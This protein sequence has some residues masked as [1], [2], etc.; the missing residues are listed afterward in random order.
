MNY[1]SILLHR[2]LLAVLL[3]FLFLPFSVAAYEPLLYL[4]SRPSLVNSGEQFGQ[5]AVIALSASSYYVVQVH[6]GLTL[7]GLIALKTNKEEL[8]QG[9]VSLRKLFRTSVFILEY[10]SFKEKLKTSNPQAWFMS[11]FRIAG[12]LADFLENEKTELNIISSTLNSNQVSVIVAGLKLQL[13]QLISET[14]S[15]SSFMQTANQ[16]EAEFLQNLEAEKESMLLSDLDSVF[17]A[18]LQ[19]DDSAREYSSQLSQLKAL[20][21]TADTDVDTKRSLSGAADLPR[22][23]TQNIGAWASVVPSL[24]SSLD[25]VQ[26]K[27]NTQADVFVQGMAVRLKREKAF[28]DQFAEDMQL[29]NKAGENFASLKQA[30]DVILSSSN[31]SLWKEQVRV[32]QLAD[33][34]AKA[35][36]FFSTADY[37][38]AS[39]YAVK[40]KQDVVFIVQSG[41][42]DSANSKDAINYGLLIS[43]AVVILVMLILVI[44]FRNRKKLSGLIQGNGNESELNIYDR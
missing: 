16:N 42:M 19:L 13:D 40:G 38:K 32:N 14:Q 17:E 22:D 21:A 6:S 28:N 23:F 25:Q 41:F 27:A 30:V 39:E 26:S 20:I 15:L 1:N 36:S 33:N 4:Q 18:V 29:K 3:C 12:N 8:E 5:Y 7:S 24:Q 9:E 37:L 31:R 10:S 2:K 34:W 11:E 43:G 35:Q 44:F